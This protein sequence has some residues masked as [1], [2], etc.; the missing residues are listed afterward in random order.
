MLIKDFEQFRREK[1]RIQTESQIEYARKT[2]KSSPR[3]RTPETQRT[4]S[5]ELKAIQIEATVKTPCDS[6]LLFGS[7]SPRRGR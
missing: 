1:K 4:P 5:R 3:S 7:V 6:A 2:R